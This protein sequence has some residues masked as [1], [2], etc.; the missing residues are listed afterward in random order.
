[1][2]FLSET[3]P[4][5]ENLIKAEAKRQALTLMLIPSENYASK[6]VEAAVGSSLGNKY[7]EGYPRKR[8]YQGQTFVDQVEQLAIDRAKK[9]F[10]VSHVN[11]QP[12]SGSPA[13]AAVYFNLIKPG[14]KIMG[15]TLSHGGHLT[16][17]HPGITLSGKFYTSVQY[18]VNKDGVIDY[19]ELEKF[20]VKEKPA[21]I[22]AGTTA[23]PRILDF[24][25][26]SAIA[27][28]VDAYL[29]ADISHIAGLVIAG[30]HPS[31]ARYADI[32]S[33]TTHK[34]LRGPRGAMVMVTHVGL[35]KDPDLAKKIDKAVFPGLQGGPHIN[36]IA[37]I[38][39][40][41]K[42]ASMAR[43]K[44]YGH[45]VVEN[46][47][48]L[49]ITLQQYGVELTTGGT[50]NHLM[51]VDL[52]PIGVKGKDAAIKLEEAG[53]IA[54]Y[55]TVPYDPN[56]PFNPSGLRLGTPAVTSRGMKTKE[57]KQIGNWI[58]DVLTGRETPAK[59]KKAVEALCRQY[60]IKTTY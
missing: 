55:N 30:A 52:R 1:M 60:P 45:Q 41:L 19:D 46:A 47:R 17:G 37:G 42:E 3:D 14:S 36:T 58:T 29:L 26:F 9:L 48:T 23:Y 49:A 4:Q 27:K 40:A 2:A 43:F 57:M 54:N 32:I 10:E 44:K 33:T 20:A 31:P 6:A 39:V 21:I 25:R 12:Y 51:V 59:V 56:P 18:G 24:K 53:I 34:T 22:V 13:N 16:H 15:L 11:V 8:Y 35:K 38:A 28:K 5:I 7:A 50:D